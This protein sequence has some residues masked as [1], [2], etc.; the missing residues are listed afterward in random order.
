MLRFG[1]FDAALTPAY[2]GVIA[3]AIYGMSDAPEFVLLDA[4]A[5]RPGALALSFGFSS[6]LVVLAVVLARPMSATPPAPAEII[7][8][9]AMARVPLWL[10]ANPAP[11][12]SQG[13]A[14]PHS[15]PDPPSQESHPLPVADPPAEAAA[16]VDPPAAV[17]P[18][19]QPSLQP[20]PS[21][22][23]SP[24][25]K[26]APEAA[27]VTHAP[28]SDARK[29]TPDAL[30]TL[31]LPRL[32]E[33]EAALAASLAALPPGRRLALPSVSIRVDAEWLEALPQ[34]KEE[35]YFSVTRPQRDTE[36]LAYLPATHSFA[37]KC[38]LQPLWQIR[39]GERVPALA[40]L[41]SAAASR[42]GV[43]SELVGLYTWHPL[44]LENALRMFVLARM[45]HMG[46]QLGPSEVVTVRFAS[47]PDGCLMSLEPIRGAESR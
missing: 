10:P 17:L 9:I 2:A 28:A 7:S 5:P 36:V 4:G 39:E 47:G 31:P 3:T 26:P 33:D 15:D 12:D 1:D 30:G 35:L 20:P 37:L 24:D 14:T 41:R 27:G 42:L 13:S 8:E 44:V 23:I 6:A 18:K 40:A 21:Q 29:P 43:S 32:I 22:V 45:E 38:P 34:T 46:V 25:S 19:L 16:P 11:L